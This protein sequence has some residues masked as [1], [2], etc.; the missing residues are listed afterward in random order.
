ML[1]KE[2]SCNVSTSLHNLKQNNKN[3]VCA[4]YNLVRPDALLLLLTQSALTWSSGDV[5]PAL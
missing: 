3:Q 1:L 5:K 2:K 4:G